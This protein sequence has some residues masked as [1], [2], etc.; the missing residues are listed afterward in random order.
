VAAAYAGSLVLDAEKPRDDA[1]R[2][3]VTSYAEV[4]VAHDA[5]PESTK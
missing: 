1:L 2:F 4:V 5:R 3:I